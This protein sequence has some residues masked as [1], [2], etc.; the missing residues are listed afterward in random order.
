MKR[1]LLISAGLA[2]LALTAI[3]PTPQLPDSPDKSAVIEASA[4]EA[5]ALNVGT[6]DSYTLGAVNVAWVAPAKLV[7]HKLDIV[8][9]SLKEVPALAPDVGKVAASTSIPASFCL[10]DKSKRGVS[11]ATVDQRRVRTSASIVSK[12]LRSASHYRATTDL[13]RRC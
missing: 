12:H 6:L 2:A 11:V 5:P 1:I 13:N 10:L 9:E 3:A 7:F 8:G 4:H